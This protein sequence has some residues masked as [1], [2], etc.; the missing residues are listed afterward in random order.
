MR[1]TDGMNNLDKTLARCRGTRSLFMAHM[2]AG[3]PSITESLRIGKALVE[4]GADI[5]EVQIPFSDP[6]A[7]GS[8]ITKACHDALAQGTKITDAFL[9][10]QGITKNSNT[11]PVVIMSYLNPVFRYGITKFVADA[12]SAGASGIIVPDAPVD[13]EEGKILYRETVKHDL[14]LILVISPGV[15]RTRLYALK[16][17][18][19]GFVYCTSRQGTTGVKGGFAGD[20]PTYLNVV[21]EIFDLPVGLGFGIKTRNDFQVAARISDIVIAG[22]VFVESATRD[23]VRGAAGALR[24]L[25]GK[26]T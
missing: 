4:G 15:S 18:A 5:V 21:R 9:V 23:G 2:I 3:Y 10:V 26:L 11:T 24:T 7:D 13:S 12:K 22:S 25:L 17:Y 19:S 8:V 16:L 20:L 14:H 6:L 1:N